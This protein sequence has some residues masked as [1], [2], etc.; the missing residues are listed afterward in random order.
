M[1]EIVLATTS[2]YKQQ[3]FR[4][5]NIPFRTMAAD[6]SETSQPGENAEYVAKRLAQEKAQKIANSAKDCLIIGADQCAQCDEKLVHKPGS[7][8]GA[9]LDLQ[10][11]SGKQI[12][13]YTSVC[14]I[15]PGGE[16][17][18]FT[19]K[20]S[21]HFRT[22]THEEIENYLRIEQPYDCAGAFK[23]EGLGI[24]LFSSFE[25]TDPT[26]IIGLPLI[27][28]SQALRDLGFDCYSAS[29]GAIS[30]SSNSSES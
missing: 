8:H 27:Q 30:S 1:L 23:A 15:T 4:R 5:L 21:V 26:A 13:F 17:A 2:I 7:H 19:D 16:I 11:Y 10:E 18:Q 12:V 25:T 24:S 29:S 20:T 22:L 14:L 9:L 28:L 3:L 6:I